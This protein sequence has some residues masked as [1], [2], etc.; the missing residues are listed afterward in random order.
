[1]LQFECIKFCEVSVMAKKLTSLFASMMLFISNGAQAKPKNSEQSLKIENNK[2]VGNSLKIDNNR[3]KK[4]NDSLKTEDFITY[5]YATLF[6]GGGLYYGVP[7][8]RELY[9]KYAP[10]KPL[11]TKNQ[12]EKNVVLNFEEKNKDP[13]K[14]IC[15]NF[16]HGENEYEKF[17][18]KYLGVGCQGSAWLFKNKMTGELVVVKKIANEK[19]KEC[20]K[21]A[22]E[23]REMLSACEYF[24]KPLDY[25]EENGVAYAV[26][27]YIE[28]VGYDQFGN[29]V[30]NSEKGVKLL[31]C[32]ILIQVV[33]ACKYL[34][35]RGFCRNDTT[36]ENVLLIKDQ[37]GE[38]KVKFV[39]YGCFKEEIK[40]ALYCVYCFASYLNYPQGKYSLA[41]L[42]K[43][44][45]YKPIEL[46]DD[47]LED[48]KGNKTLDN[49]MS[50][51][52]T[53]QFFENEMKK[54]DE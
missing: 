45:N 46:M 39:D 17:Q 18:E 19:A 48:E 26:Y 51:D 50:Y 49:P 2:N 4:I 42:Y 44:A 32:K 9:K 13:K 6:L 22:Y 21:L 41:E 10:V 43:I 24:S 15:P 53:I 29:I 23:K 5:L 28:S 47:F 14:N 20:E 27:E 7:Y 38:P 35:E 54:V 30:Q 31:Y 37:Q 8:C 3:S 11:N 16:K 1:M 12:T 36:V 40:S 33:K 52:E 25:F 34:N